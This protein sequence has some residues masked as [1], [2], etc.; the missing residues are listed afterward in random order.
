MLYNYSQISFIDINK[1]ILY[2][3]ESLIIKALKS[4]LTKKDIKNIRIKKSV[5]SIPNYRTL[6][7]S[8]I[9]LRLNLLKVFCNLIP[10]NHQL[11]LDM[12]HILFHYEKS[13]SSFW[14]PAFVDK[15][16][17]SDSPDSTYKL[18][19]HIIPS[20]YGFE[21]DSPQSIFFSLRN[22]FS[23]RYKHKIGHAF[24]VLQENDQITAATGMT[25]ETNYQIFYDLIFR[26][27]GINFLFQMFRGR[28]ESAD[29]VLSDIQHHQNLN[30]IKT[31]NFNINKNQY[32]KCYNYL[33][34]WCEQGHYKKYGLA[35]KPDTDKGAGCVSFALNFLKIT[36]IVSDYEMKKWTRKIE[37]P[38]FLISNPKNDVGLFLLVY[39]LLMNKK[40][41]NDNEQYQTIEFLDPDLIYNSLS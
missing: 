29:F 28:L 16:S 34:N 5:F 19:I 26:R 17:I 39:R 31:L 33:S 1:R 38:N 30:K 12:E 6:I 3:Y 21:W 18:S 15:R 22:Y 10:N 36:G 35:F 37:I 4:G 11:F 20:P 41:I 14:N 2:Y 23:I 27:K 24:I 25:G 8:K 32:K 9:N 7:L 40:W 13:D